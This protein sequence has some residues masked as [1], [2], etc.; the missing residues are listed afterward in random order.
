MQPDRR[1]PGL[2]RGDV[3]A[4]RRPVGLGRV[5]VRRAV[6]G[7]DPA[8]AAGHLR[9]AAQPVPRPAGP[10]GRDR[11][12]PGQHRG[13]AGEVAG[14]GAGVQRRRPAV[15]PHRRACGEP[16]HRVRRGREPGA[17]AEFGGRRADVPA[18]LVH[19]GIRLSPVRATGIVLV[20]HLRVRASRPGLRGNGREAG[21]ERVVVRRASARRGGSRGFDRRAVHRRVHGVQPTGNRCRC[22]SRRLPAS[23]VAEGHRRLRPAERA[24]ANVRYRRS[25]RAAE[26]RE[27][28]HR[29]QSEPQDRGAG[30]GRQGGGLLRKRQGGRWP[31]RV[32]AVGYRLRGAGGRSG[33]AHRVRGRL[34]RERHAGASE[35]RRHRIAGGCGRRRSA[36]A[37]R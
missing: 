19:V 14:H 12:H 26:P 32:V 4:A 5:R 9:G 37:H 7:E 15:R 17:A 23:L 28:P 3:A 30:R 11:P 21:P 6:A 35:V 33:Q 20:S 31:R 25:A 8:A 16:F 10:R 29:L 22:R 2:G 36:V 24:P 1:E 34:A 27:E 13:R 18:L